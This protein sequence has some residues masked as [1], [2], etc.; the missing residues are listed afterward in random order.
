MVPFWNSCFNSLSC[1]SCVHMSQQRF[2]FLDGLRG[3]AAFVV[4]LFHLNVAIGI[5][6][7]SVMPSLLNQIFFTGHLGIQIFFV[8]SGFVIAYSLREVKIDAPF[9]I[10]FF[11]KRSLRLDP[12]YWAVMALIIFLALI[13][14]FTFKSEEEF[15]F[16]FLQIFYNAT[17]TAD[18]VKVPFVL[19]VAWTLCIEFQFYMFFAL[20]MLLIT[21]LSFSKSTVGY[22]W[23][24]LLLFSLLQNTTLAIIPLK[25]VTFIPHWY[26]FF[27]G[28][29]TCWG[30]LDVIDKKLVLLNYALVAICCLWMTTPHAMT[31]LIIAT[32]LYFVGSMGKFHQLLTHSFFQ[33][34]G[35]ISYSLY[36]IH[37]PIGMKV[38]DLGFSLIK[39]YENNLP[40][41]LVLFL[42]SITAIFIVTDLFY[43][44]IEL[45][46]HQ[47]SRR[48][49]SK[50]DFIKV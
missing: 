8:L 39:G 25:P 31:S 23:T 28:C 32:C 13:A 43:R 35:K 41:V 3:I 34:T 46:S 10:R 47:L 24:S 21:K 33:Y 7:P 44:F 19:P 14:H 36:L 4:V 5:H 45:P 38:V 26:S 40:V 42:S 2:E 16:S 9:F 49:F 11:L 50:Q 20:L 27:L 12:A 6:S 37:W 48:L 1:V 22:L 30:F 15:P 17:Y 29:V 18:L